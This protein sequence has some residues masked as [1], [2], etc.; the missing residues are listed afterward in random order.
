M[1][2]AQRVLA[3][4]RAELALVEAGRADELDQLAAAWQAAL[5]ALPAPL[6]PLAAAHVREALATTR[7]TRA[8]LQAARDAVA[9]ELRRIRRTR[10]GAQGYA[11]AGMP[12]RPAVDHAV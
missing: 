5:A 1:T 7:R 4:A 6:D 11:P 3:L 10:T 8:G 2:P 9:D 12:G